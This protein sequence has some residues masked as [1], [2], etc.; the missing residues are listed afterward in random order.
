LTTVENSAIPVPR[1][2]QIGQNEPSPPDAAHITRQITF[3]VM[4]V[5]SRR[6]TS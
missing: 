1:I 6:R 3:T 5:A 2:T 4:K